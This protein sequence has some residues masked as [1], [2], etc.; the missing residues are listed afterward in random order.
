LLSRIPALTDVVSRQIE[1]TDT[2]QEI[3][4]EDPVFERKR[5]NSR[6]SGHDH[7]P[8]DDVAEVSVDALIAFIDMELRHYDSA[9]SV[10][11]GDTVPQ[12]DT[13]QA[14]HAPANPVAA[15]AMKAYGGGMQPAPQPMPQPAPQS[16]TSEP[17]RDTLDD[18][19]QALLRSHLFRLK[20]LRDK[21]VAALT[22][23]RGG[24]FL[25][26]LGEAIADAA[27]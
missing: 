6:D 9:A 21:G 5:K 10:S 27:G 4:H 8:I 15:A 14:T 26:A 23:R 3:Q 7:A 18:S 17:P 2:R 13:A 19:G 11:T 1:T 22:I 25:D 16:L 12:E 24:T 20:A